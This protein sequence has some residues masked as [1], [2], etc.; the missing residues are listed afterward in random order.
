M[1]YN[2]F[3]NFYTAQSYTSDKA[4]GLHLRQK[5]ML[6]IIIALISWTFL[7]RQISYMLHLP[8]LA[9]KNTSKCNS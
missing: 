4:T 2:L 1:K 5:M 6:E 3:M 8:I 7:S 9:L